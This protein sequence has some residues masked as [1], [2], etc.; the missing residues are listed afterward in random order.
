MI[1]SFGYAIALVGFCAVPLASAVADTLTDAQPATECVGAD[2]FDSLT[3]EN[4]ALIYKSVE[5]TPYAKGIRWVATKD[6]ARIEII[7]TYHF[8]DPRHDANVASLTPIIAEAGALLVE[9]GPVEEKRLTEEIATNPELMIDAQG[10]TLP[11]RMDDEEWTKL[12]DA[13]AQRGVPAVMVSR[14]RPWYIAMMLGISPCMLSQIQT[15]GDT[16]GLDHLLIDVAQNEGTPIVALE[17]WDTALSVFKGM[18]P[19]EELD[20]IRA[21]LPTALLADDYAHTTIEAY[22]RGDIWAIWEFMRVDAYETSG[23]DKAAVD[24]QIDMAE[25]RL[26]VERNKRWIAPLT[27]AATEAAADGKPVVAAFG[28]LHL[29]GEHG[30]LK[31]LEKDGWTVAEGA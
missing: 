23:L 13:M 21:T 8:S 18:T 26:M 27:Q 6:D 28:A 10:P 17:P 16:N 20:M 2:L 19:E 15:T 12:S 25:E 22:F 30:V 5:A 4:R 1:K 7:G 24:R 29:P 31:L 14:M 9:G 11:E 3:V